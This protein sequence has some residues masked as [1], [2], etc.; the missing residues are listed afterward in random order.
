MRKRNNRILWLL[1][2]RTLMPYEVPLLKEL[3]FEVFVPKVMPV[4]ARLRSWILDFSHDAS[5]SIPPSALQRLNE[6]NFY[7]SVWPDDIVML[8]NRYFGTAFV[9]PHSVQVPEALSKF[10]GQLVLRAF[11]LDNTQ[12]YS[13]LFEILYGPDVWEKIRA[14]GQRF[15]FGE[16]YEQLH[17][18]EPPLLSERALFLPLGIPDSI[19]RCADS[20]VGGMNK[21][22]FVCPNCVTDPYY[23]AVYKQFKKDFGD[24]PHVIV[25]AQDVSTDDPN[26]AGFVSDEELERLYR[27]CAVLY[28]HS[29]ELRHVHYS[30]I[31]AAI[32]GMPVI[33]YANSLLGRL[34][35]PN[36]GGCFQGFPAARAAIERILAGDTDFTEALRREQRSLAYKFSHDYCKTS[37][38]KSFAST[39]FKAALAPEAAVNVYA[40]ETWRTLLR[41]FAKGLLRPI[42]VE[43]VPSAEAW[44]QNQT[45]HGFDDHA[46]MEQGIDF[47][48]ETYPAFV[49]S[50]SGL[51]AQEFWGRWSVGDK[52]LICLNHVL[53]KKFRLVIVGGAYGP[54]IGAPVSIKVGNVERVIRFNQAADVPQTISV[55]FVLRRYTSTIEITVPRPVIPG[56]DSRA[57]GLG[58][59]NLRADPIDKF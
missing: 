14:L 59:V 11:G 27:E 23:A 58:L 37:W 38:L 33:F 12:S 41:P 48:N 22:L 47:A 18:C 19:W 32:N 24:L 54:N 4:N 39:G 31:E 34:T 3:G 20:W 44:Q 55:D 17:E 57:I 42:V 7:E 43:P 53:E 30:P 5:L 35:E 2:H 46:T 52:I 50:I 6:F 28:Y 45:D 40:R 29:T 56:G 13:T 49:K 1:N 9:I 15:W 26:I 10:E 51:S 16:G 36:A 8:V 21:I 25:G